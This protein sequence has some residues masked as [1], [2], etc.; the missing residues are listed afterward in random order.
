M[1]SIQTE[2]S[3][4]QSEASDK[5]NKLDKKFKCETCDKS[6]AH[7]ASLYNHKKICNGEEEKPAEAAPIKPAKPTK[8]PKSAAAAAEPESAPAPAKQTKAVK[9]AVPAKAA[10]AKQ[11]KQAQPDTPADTDIISNKYNVAQRDNV[12]G[13]ENIKCHKEQETDD[14]DE[15]DSDSS[16]GQSQQQEPEQNV[17]IPKSILLL[18]IQENKRMKELLVSQ[19]EIINSLTAMNASSKPSGKKTVDGYLNENCDDAVSL[20]DFIKNI[21]ITLD[22]LIVTKDD[23]LAQGIITIFLQNLKKLP[24]SKRPM[25]CTDTKR[26]TLYIKGDKWEKDV[27]K[28]R[29]REAISTVARKQAQQIKLWKDVNPDCMKSSKGKDDFVILVKNI[30]EDI[31][32]KTDKII[33]H[34]CKSIYISKAEDL[35]D[36]KEAEA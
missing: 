20:E 15:E 8:Q 23:G 26:C 30:T 24:V 27:N 4:I 35:S 7:K 22:N 3:A 10:P 28:E 11:V 2:N 18:L 17:I 13:E 19:N 36:E 33:K 21:E 34:I 31:D 16:E 32:E 14:S 6:Y 9:A 12:D 1:S 5:S 25:H 29:I